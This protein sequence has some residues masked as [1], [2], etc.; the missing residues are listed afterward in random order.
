MPG[1][2]CPSPT[3]MEQGEGVAQELPQVPGTP[4]QQ[5]GLATGV[6]PGLGAGMYPGLQPGMFQQQGFPAMPPRIAQQQQCPH[7]GGPSWFGAQW[8]PRAPG[9][10]PSGCQNLSSANP[11]SWWCESQHA[12]WKPEP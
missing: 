10:G 11:V 4:S 12:P 1:A 9:L 8:V 6:G 2:G 3:R 7:A 5:S